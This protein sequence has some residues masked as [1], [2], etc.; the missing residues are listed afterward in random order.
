MGVTR[1]EL[2]VGPEGVLLDVMVDGHRE[3]IYITGMGEVLGS[4]HLED[5]CNG[6]NCVIHNPSDHP[7]RG[8]PTHWRRDRYLMERVCEHGVGH[9]D[10]DD[11]T[12][13]KT[14]GCDGCCT[15]E[16]PGNRDEVEHQVGARALS[17]GLP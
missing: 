6:P 3:S 14:H 7:L 13:D 8:R 1:L 17:G 2:E 5:E 4:V 11:I 12:L 10:P 9:P 15:G 16:S